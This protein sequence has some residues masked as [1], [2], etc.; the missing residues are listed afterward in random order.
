MD[1][2]GFSALLTAD[3][4]ALLE[5]LPPYREDAALGLGERLRAEGTPLA[6]PRVV[7]S[8]ARCP[9]LPADAG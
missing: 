3:G 8:E 7:L 6:G 5:A 1:D 2:A 4:W 9:L